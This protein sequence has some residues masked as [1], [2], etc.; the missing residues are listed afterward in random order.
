[1]KLLKFTRS[2]WEMAVACGGNKENVLRDYDIQKEHKA[3]KSLGQ[4]AIKYNLSKMQIYRIVKD[5]S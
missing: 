2:Y 1:M 5:N 4:L 3:G